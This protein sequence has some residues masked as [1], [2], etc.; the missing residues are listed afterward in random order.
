[1]HRRFS[2]LYIISVGAEIYRDVARLTAK[3]VVKADG[4]VALRVVEGNRQNPLAL[5]GLNFLTNVHL[6]VIDALSDGVSEVRSSDRFVGL[7][8][9]CQGLKT[10]TK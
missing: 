3:S 1:M 5:K 2:G 8:V 10:R 4:E 6:C 9:T 7:T